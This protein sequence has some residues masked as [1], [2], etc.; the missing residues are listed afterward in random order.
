MGEAVL[1]RQ[2]QPETQRR[3]SKVLNSHRTGVPYPFSRVTATVAG[4]RPP[5]LTRARGARQ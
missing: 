1:A 5:T 2:G 3:T 4:A